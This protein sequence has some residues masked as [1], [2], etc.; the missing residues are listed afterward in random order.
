M[1]ATLGDVIREARTEQGHK[2]R[3]FAKVLGIS[4]THLSDVEH[5]RRVPSD[6]VLEEIAKQLGLDFDELMNLAGKLGDEIEQFAQQ[7]PEAAALFRKVSSARP[8]SDVLKQL[9]AA[10]EKLLNDGKRR[11]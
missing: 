8:S 11:R 5:N 2:L 3:P 10:L 4:P 6:G 1:K 7:R 9:D